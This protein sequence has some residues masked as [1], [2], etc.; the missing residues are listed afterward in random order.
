MYKKNHFKSSYLRYFV[1]LVSLVLIPACCA[2]NT[3]QTSNDDLEFVPFEPFVPCGDG[4][5]AG[6][7]RER[8][9]G[10]VMN[11]DH[12]VVF[13][14][15]GV[16][17]GDED[18]LDVLEEEPYKL[19]SKLLPPSLHGHTILSRNATENPVASNFTRWIVPY[20]SQD[21]YLGSGDP[22]KE[23]Q[24]AGDII[25]ESA[26]QYWRDSVESESIN[27]LIVTGI[28][29]GAIGLLNHFESVQEISRAVNASKL[30][31][32]MDSVSIGSKNEEGDIGTVM[33]E[34]VD[35][36]KHPLCNLTHT[37][38]QNIHPIELW[39]VPCCISIHCMLENDPIFRNWAQTN[40]ETGKERLLLFD[41]MYDP[42]A[43]LGGST[44][45]P[46]EPSLPDLDHFEAEVL[47]TAGARGQQF[48][49]S[50]YRTDARLGNR[51]LWAVT[52]ALSH[53]FLLPALEIDQIRCDFNAAHQ[54]TE[55]VCREDG[56]GKINLMFSLSALHLFS[57]PSHCSVFLKD[58]VGNFSLISM[59]P[60][61]R[62][63]TLGSSHQ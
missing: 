38:T 19:S 20:C 22:S 28:S 23:I 4:S 51:V 25:F 26:L 30:R 62:L 45:L 46:S 57:S 52:S 2:S 44:G 5:P 18:C 49:Q 29:A 35:L 54:L 11:Q 27:A 6:I 21:V 47:Q 32:I 48:V 8:S 34:V 16:C 3:N 37:R 42:I 9:L 31:L 15:G 33:E 53:A 12:I 7:Y 10:D 24:R 14:G 40:D 63:Q 39:G 50:T 61:G 60:S 56:I 55:Y 58:F 41:S 1:I 59:R 17:R 36:D 43:L 13:L